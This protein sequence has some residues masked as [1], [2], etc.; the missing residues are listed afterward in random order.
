MFLPH[1]LSDN[2]VNDEDEDSLIEKRR[3][4]RKALVDVR[5]YSSSSKFCII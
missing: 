1:S 2:S 4:A 3:K 5:K